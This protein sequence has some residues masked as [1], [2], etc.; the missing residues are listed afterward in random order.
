[1][2]PYFKTP[3]FYLDTIYC[4]YGYKFN[5]RYYFDNKTFWRI[6]KNRYVLTINK[7]KNE[8][9]QHAYKLSM[10]ELIIHMGTHES[11]KIIIKMFKEYNPIIC[12]S[13]K[14]K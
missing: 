9:Q 13:N 14:L 11:E 4:Y 3:H 2:F 5:Y 6:M 10:N 8:K 12:F 1:M 7:Q